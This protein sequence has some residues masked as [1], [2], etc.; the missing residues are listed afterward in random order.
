VKIRQ[1]D[2]KETFKE[3][4]Q[5]V[6]DALMTGSQFVNVF[7]KSHGTKYDHIYDEELFFSFIFVDKSFQALIDNK[8]GLALVLLGANSG[9]FNMHKEISENEVS[10]GRM[11]YD[12]IL[13]T[14][15]E[16]IYR[17]HKVAIKAFN[18]KGLGFTWEGFRKEI[19]LLAYVDYRL[20]IL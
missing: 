3:E 17:G 13:C 20:Y 14:V 4:R 19:S 5:F 10:F 11:L 6:G 9:V 8:K 18:P 2:F 1:T 16:G 7:Y 15:Y 12:S